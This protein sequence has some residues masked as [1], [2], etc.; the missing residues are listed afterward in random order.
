VQVNFSK[1]NGKVNLD[2]EGIREALQSLP[3]GNYTLSIS[4]R[5]L[6]R[7]IDQNS[8]LWGVVYKSIGDE[9][10]YEVDEIHEMMKFKFLGMRK[11]EVNGTQLFSLNTTTQLSTAEFSDYT[12]RVKRWAAQFLNINI[13]DPK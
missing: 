7:S 10:G 8:Y 12:E 4:K 11:T 13:E 9:L 1:L 6:P 5:K 3:D 2:K